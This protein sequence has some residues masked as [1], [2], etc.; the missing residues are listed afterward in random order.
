MSLKPDAF[1]KQNLEGLEDASAV[2]SFAFCPNSANECA[3]A[4]SNSAGF[5]YN[6][7]SIATP[8]P[9]VNTFNPNVSSCLSS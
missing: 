9:L 3:P 5:N 6:Y 2:G 7:N 1:L 4:Q 8:C